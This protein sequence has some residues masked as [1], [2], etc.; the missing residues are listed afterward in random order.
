VGEC[1]EEGQETEE[2]TEGRGGGLGVR[3]KSPRSEGPCSHTCACAVDRCGA[4]SIPESAAYCSQTTC[5]ARRSAG[6]R[7]QRHCP[8]APPPAA[9]RYETSSVSCV[10]KVKSSIT[11]RAIILSFVYSQEDFGQNV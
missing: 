3:D 6:R 8:P 1:V 11:L 9:R 4:A 5:P 7:P 10:A 2:S